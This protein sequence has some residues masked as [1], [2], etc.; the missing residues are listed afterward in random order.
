MA[1]AL[2]LEVLAM[3]LGGLTAHQRLRYASLVCKRWRIAA[4]KATTSFAPAAPT[5]LARA[6]R[7]LSCVERLTLYTIPPVA[8][9][10]P[11]FPNMRSLSICRYFSDLPMDL[12][13]MANAEVLCAA[14]KY[15]SP[16]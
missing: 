14:C 11:P 4:I 7:V 15:L 5:N 6:A 9:E 1:A 3:V 16:V 12:N 13:A 10:G 8:F 2:P